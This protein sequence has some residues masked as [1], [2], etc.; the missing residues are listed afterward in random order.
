[1][2]RNGFCLCFKCYR[3]SNTL[4]PHHSFDEEGLDYEGEDEESSGDDE[5]EDE[6]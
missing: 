5:E 2:C 6:E 4:H 3:S 1:M